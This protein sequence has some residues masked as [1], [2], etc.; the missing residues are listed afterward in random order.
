MALSYKNETEKS[1]FEINNILLYN[2][3]QME[4]AK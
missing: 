3:Q 2:E 1:K 4:I